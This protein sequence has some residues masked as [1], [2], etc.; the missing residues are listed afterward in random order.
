MGMLNVKELT[1]PVALEALIKRV[2]EHVIWRKLY[3]LPDRSLSKVKQFMENHIWVE[4]VSL[5]RDEP[6]CFYKDN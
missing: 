4:E 5:L 6:P 2:R 3:V 1:E